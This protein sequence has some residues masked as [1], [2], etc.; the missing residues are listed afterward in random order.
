[1]QSNLFRKYIWLADTIYRKQRIKFADIDRLWQASSLSESKPMALRTFHNH[2]AAIEELFDINIGCDQRTKEYFIEDGDIRN[3][4]M[5]AWLLNSFS[6]SNLLYENKGI[7]D[8]ILLEEVPS[9]QIYLNDMLEAIRNNTRINITYKSYSQPE[10]VVVELQP[11]F[12]KLHERRWYVYGATEDDSTVKVYALDR[13]H[14]IEHT[15]EG[16]RLPKDFDPRQH[17]RH[18]VGIEKYPHIA[19][20]KVVL[21][22]F[23][24][25]YLRSLPLHRSQIEAGTTRYGHTLFMY[26]LAPTPE[27]FREILRMGDKVTVVQPQ[28]AKEEIKTMATK[29]LELYN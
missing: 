13:I 27:F 20:C 5:R 11:Y 1:M 25:E 16:F 6:A 9:A 21:K 3:G 24:P 2:R 19:P 4:D 10:S 12:V 28:W 26:Y 7:E 18:S 14:G 22:T 17:L 23:T 8:R 15:T 29:I